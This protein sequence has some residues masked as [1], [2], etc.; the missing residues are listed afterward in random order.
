MKSAAALSVSM[1]ILAATLGS[2]SI[3]RSSVLINGT[4]ADVVLRVANE[5]SSDLPPEDLV[6]TLKTSASRTIPEGMAA[7]RGIRLSTPSCRYRFDLPKLD[8]YVWGAGR[9]PELGDSYPVSLQVEPDFTI[10]L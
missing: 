8:A 2:C 6:V 10:Y 5:G 1:I 3:P 9:A 4:G 7:V